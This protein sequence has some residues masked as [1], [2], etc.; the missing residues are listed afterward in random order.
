MKDLHLSIV[1][2]IMEEGFGNRNLQI[3]DQYVSDGF[4][5]HQFGSKNGKEGL[6]NTILQL[7]ESLSGFRYVLLN[8]ISD[9]DIIW[10]HYKAFAIQ[11]GTFMNLPPSGKQISIEIMDIFRFE[12]GLLSEH[13]G[14]PDRFAAMIQLGMLTKKESVS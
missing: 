14:I 7:H 9:G 4:I 2:N 11:S 5:E 8:S 3:I 10:T 1:K 13:W 6:K 12:N